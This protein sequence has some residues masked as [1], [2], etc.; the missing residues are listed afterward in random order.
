[1]KKI[2][3]IVAVLM[4]L[5]VSLTLAGCGTKQNQKTDSDYEAYDGY[6]YYQAN[7]EWRSEVFSGY[8]SW[9]EDA[10]LLPGGLAGIYRR[11]LYH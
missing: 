2:V 5:A 10:L 1:M 4:L 9:I 6:A 8:E 7:G 11:D 3:S